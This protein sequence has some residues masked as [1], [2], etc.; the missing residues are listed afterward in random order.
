MADL[1]DRLREDRAMRD[2]AK[3]LVTN[4]I[5]NLRGDLDEKGLAARFASRMKEGAEGVVEESTAFA[6][7]NPK[8]VSS[9]FAIGLGLLLAWIFREPL[10]KFLDQLMLRHWDEMQTSD[11]IEVEPENNAESGAAE[12]ASPSPPIRNRRHS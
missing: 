7:E 9:G 1:K 6:K 12:L 4:D 8:R 11:Q 3:S 10:A 2:A 5:A